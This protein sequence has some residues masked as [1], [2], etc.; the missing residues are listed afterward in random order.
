M[1]PY[2]KS[3]FRKRSLKLFL[4]KVLNNLRRTPT[5]NQRKWFKDNGDNTLRLS[6][7]LNEESVFI[8]V[9]GYK[10]Y[11]AKKIVDKFN[12]ITYIF[13]PDHNYFDILN[14]EFKNNTKIINK[15]L[16]SFDG[17]VNLIE[18]GDSSFISKNKEQNLNVKTV[19]MISF[20]KFIKNENLK[21]IDLISIN[22]EG[23][24]YE[25][26]HHIIEKEHATRIKNFQI[27]FHKNVKGHRKLKKSLTSKLSIT[28]ELE[29]SYNYVWES[30]KL[31]N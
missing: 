16:G 26:L 27:Q 13:E 14:N 31:K 4:K 8:E 6:Y 22:I 29:W 18:K 9:G 17:T 23:G 12:P 30:W 11:Y 19:E 25:L 21:L 7:S 28:H 10:G 15:A 24:E 20:D 2:F 1:I 5:L 3:I